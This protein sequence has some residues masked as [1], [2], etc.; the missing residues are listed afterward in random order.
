[1]DW[2]INYCRYLLIA[3]W[4]IYIKK[5]LIGYIWLLSYLVHFLWNCTGMDVNNSTSTMVQVMAWGRQATSHYMGQCWPGISGAIWC[6][7]PTGIQCY[8]C[9]VVC[10]GHC[11]HLCRC[12]CSCLLWRPKKVLKPLC[13][14]S[15]GAF[16]THTQYLAHNSKLCILHASK[17]NFNSSS[18]NICCYNILLEM[19]K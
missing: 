2:A 3:T 8:S 11:R 17:S 15:Q 10:S 7:W 9:I 1:M 19:E 5:S 13:G 14:N 6:L 16:Y 18:K 4:Q 12:Y